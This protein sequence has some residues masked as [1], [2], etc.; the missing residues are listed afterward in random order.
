MINGARSMSHTPNLAEGYAYLGFP[1]L[2]STSDYA[3]DIAAD[4]F[5]EGNSPVWIHTE[6]QTAGR[7]RRGRVWESRSGN[8]S[9]TLLM[10]PQVDAQKGAELSFVIALA[11]SDVLTALSPIQPI[12]L[13]WPNDVLLGGKKIAGI[14]LESSASSDGPLDWLSIG[15]GVNLAFHPEDTPYPAT[16]LE[17]AKIPAP[18]AIVFLEALSTAFAKR[19]ANWQANGFK[20]TR[21]AWLGRAK[22]RDEPVE[23]RLADE[24]VRGTF[25]DLDHMGALVLQLENGTRRL[26]TA[27]EV[28]F[29]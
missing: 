7:G 5:A 16:S 6:V 15:C 12:E 28:F 13:K 14:L 27:G 11:L 21:E 26:I 4:W 17:A 9:A 22:G 10:R 24:V 29:V 2:G 18:S 8:L 23:A 3:R 19:Y 25:I 20:P 1:E